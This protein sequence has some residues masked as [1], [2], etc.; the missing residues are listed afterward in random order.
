[1]YSRPLAKSPTRSSPGRHQPAEKLAPLVRPSQKQ[2]Q[3]RAHSAQRV[4]LLARGTVM[5]FEIPDHFHKEFTSNVELLL[6]EKMPVMLQ[7]V[8][9]DTYTGEAAQVVKQ[10]GEVE[11]QENNTRHGDTN[12][13]NIDHKQ[14]WIFPADFDLALPVDKEDEIRMLNSPVS[15]Y[16]EAMRAAYAR[17]VNSIIATAAIGTAKTGK[18]GGTNTAYDTSMTVASDFEVA[19]THTNL[20]VEKLIEAQRLLGVNENDDDEPAYIAVTQTQI[21]GLLNQEKITSADY[22][23]VKALIAGEIN[24]FMGFTFIKLNSLANT[25]DPYRKVIFWKRSGLRFGLWNGLETSIDKRPDK[26]NLTQVLMKFT[27]AA[28]RTQEKKVGIILCNEA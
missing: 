8:D 15:P 22:A 11:F 10:F 6:Q 16:V 1:V 17:K 27:G 26:K 4:C 9:M 18:N 2:T 24:E 28:T 7:G 3:E 21:A 25:S 5:S 19:A 23:N 20:T 14:R 12:F 13:S